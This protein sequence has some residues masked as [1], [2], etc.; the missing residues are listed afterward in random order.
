M[1]NFCHT[2]LDKTTIRTQN[3]LHKMDQQSKLSTTKA[4][5][6]WEDIEA[7][8]EDDLDS[9]IF[10][11]ETADILNI[12]DP[13]VPYSYEGHSMDST[14][15]RCHNINGRSSPKRIRSA[16]SSDASIISH[17]DISVESAQ[18]PLMTPI[19]LDHKLG[20]CM[21]RLALSMK[22]SELSR[23]HIGDYMSHMICNTM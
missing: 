12:Q 16:I 11:L 8:N 18:L 3:P 13:I 23:Q 19:E 17:T 4:F 2:T 20:Q 10:D 1:R 9:F 15:K 5:S 14:K 6:T 7:L 21:S 22:R